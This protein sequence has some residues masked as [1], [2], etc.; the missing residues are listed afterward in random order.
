MTQES[1]DPAP[2][3]AAAIVAAASALTLAIGVTVGSLAGVLRLSDPTPPASTEPAPAP[4]A[5]PAV[6]PESAPETIPAAPSVADPRPP[7]DEGAVVFF[8]R[9]GRSREHRDGSRRHEEP[10]EGRG[11]E[12][13]REGHD[14]DD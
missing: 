3:R 5:A 4:E 9:S 7:V 8:D 2:T 10:R 6:A 1:K 14:H 13:E 11:H 12:H